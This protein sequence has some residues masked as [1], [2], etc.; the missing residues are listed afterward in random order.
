MSVLFILAC[1]LFFV[2]M[3]IGFVPGDIELVYLAVAINAIISVII[4]GVL[5][6]G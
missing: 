6:F 3:Y 4:L 2:I 1:A 5:C